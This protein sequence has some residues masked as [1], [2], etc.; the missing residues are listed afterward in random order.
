MELTSFALWLNQAFAGF[1]NGVFAFVVWL[2][3]SILGPFLNIFFSGLTRLG[4]HGIFFILLSLAMFCFKR[5]RMCGTAMAFAILI[6]FVATNLWVKT[7]VAR[8]RPYTD[9][10]VVW[11][12]IWQDMGQQMETDFSFPSGH[13]TIAFGSMLPFFWFQKRSWSWVGLVIAFLVA[14]SRIYLF[15]HYPSDVLGG[16][17]TGCVTGILGILSVRFFQRK[18][19]QKQVPEC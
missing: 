16:I 7:W 9:S 15:V 8:P 11:Y 3:E 10:S 18:R 12:S 2:H 14:F 5:T 1:D 4:D 19:H 17:L 6:G 13:A